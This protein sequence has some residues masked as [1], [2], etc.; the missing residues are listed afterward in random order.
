M[1]L[2]GT[3]KLINNIQ[4]VSHKLT[5]QQIVV[6]I[7]E[8]TKYPQ[9]IAIEFLNDKTQILQKYKVGDKVSVDINLRG[10][11]YNGKYY[12]NLVGWRMAHIINNEV[13]NSQQNPQREAE[14]DLPF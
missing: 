8:D 2:K 6:T 7:D 13:T 12:N 10:N 14:I 4:K 1:N 3:I 5:K 9:D 11:E